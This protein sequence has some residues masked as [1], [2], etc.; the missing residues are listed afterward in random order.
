MDPHSACLLLFL[1]CLAGFS[2]SESENSGTMGE[3]SY[4]PSSLEIDG[5]DVVSVGIPYGFQCTAECYPDCRYSWTRG[6][7]TTQGP[8]LSLR[9]LQR[10]PTQTLTCTVVNPATGR[11]ASVQKTLQVTAGPS[12]VQ[13]SGP[14]FLTYGVAS[15]F[16]CSA[17]CYPSC[18]Y[19]WTVVWEREPISSAQGN[20]ISVTPAAST[21]LSESLICEAQ[22]TISYLFISTTVSLPVASTSDISIIGDSTV[23]MGKQ[24]VFICQATCVPSC[25]F[26]WQ[27]MGKT[28]YGDQIQIPILHQGEKTKFASHLQITF[29]DYSKIEPLTCEATNVLTDTTITSTIDLT[30]IDPISVSPSSQ[31]PLPVAGKSF[32]LQCVGSQNPGSITWL[33][34]KQPMAASERVLF[35]PDNTTVTF[36]P[37]LQTD[38]GLYYCVV[39]EGGEPIQSVGYKMQVDYGPSSVVISGLDVMTVGM[40]YDFQC[41]ASCHPTCQFTWTRGNLTYQGSNLILHFEELLPTQ[42]LTCTALNP[43]TGISVTAQKTL[44]VIA[45]P[46]NIQISGPA[47]LTAGVTSNFTCSADCYPSCS[48]SW[49]VGWDWE[50]FSTAQGNTISVTPPASFV[51]S[52]TLI[53][54]AQDTA[55]NLYIYRARQLQVASLFNINIAGDSA[56]AIGKTYTYTCYVTCTPSCVFTWTFMGKTY[57]GDQLQITVSD[58][59][60]TGPLTCEATNN[61]S[62]ATISATK[63]LTVI[64]PFS[65]RPSSQALPV[66]GEPFSLQCVGPQDP[67]S[68]SW[69]K[70]GRQMPVSDVVHFS[71]DNA[72]ITF[73]S[74]L[75]D[76]EGVYKCLVVE[77]GNLTTNPLV[78]VVGGTPI[79][80]FGY[81][82]QVIYGPDEALIVKPDEEPVGEMMFTLPGSTTELQCLTDCFPACSI[83]WFYRG[84]LLATN[85]SILFTPV[86]PPYEDTLTC[87]AFNPATKKNRTAETTAV[88]PD[89]PRNVMIKGPDAL[90]IGVTASFTCSAECTPSCSF[91][92]T[93]YGKTVTGSGV[94]ITVNRQVSEESI[95]CQ[96][97]N[98]FTGKTAAVNQT[99][100]VSD[101][102]W[103]GC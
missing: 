19:S 34:N 1:T 56:V 12:N 59:P 53:C 78:A 67:A 49:T 80:S 8:E 93:L 73:S 38:E 85:A 82:M 60:K 101:P 24:Y 29:S 41:S 32:S 52:E 15:I 40:A 20:T 69:L 102:H 61:V 33:K 76:D 65:V 7:E 75:R 48:Y 88:V 37:L 77:T 23:T 55:S 96:A 100:S 74:L 11:S 79:L 57:E 70:N 58:Y 35:S 36:S 72:T 22:D 87:T 84:S 13:I 9:L 98:T 42:N 50:T 27:Y 68:I 99:L 43:A 51:G 92:W 95:S 14:A 31:T 3:I 2:A 97:E 64:D 16:T 81:L 62:H 30:V 63:N 103:C 10:V 44:L 86:T 4:G 25:N 46:S 18:S 90:E 26:A 28:L 21:V 83:N 94:D 17:D 39:A 54:K 45:G 6:N 47:F 71:P 66:A 89:G 91:T 5:V